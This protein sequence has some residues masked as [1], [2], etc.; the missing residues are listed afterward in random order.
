[1]MGRSINRKKDEAKTLNSVTVGGVTF[2]TGG[3]IIFSDDSEADYYL[4][5]GSHLKQIDG[6]LE[7]GMQTLLKKVKL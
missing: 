1:M 3:N 5:E 6:M 4:A 2:T 7:H